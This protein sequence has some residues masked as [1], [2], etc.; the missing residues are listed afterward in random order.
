MPRLKLKIASRGLIGVV[1]SA[2]LLLPS[3]APANTEVSGTV[4]EKYRPALSLEG[5]FLAAYI[6]GIGRDT[7]AAA[8][9][10]RE[11][12]RDDPRNAELVE[13]AFV[14]FL[15]DNDMP[16]AFRLAERLIASDQN[17]SLAQLALGVR[18]FKAGEHASARK[19]FTKSAR[20]RTVDLTSIL[21]TAWSWAGS[22]N[23]KKA[24]EVAGQLKGNRAYTVFRDY[25]AGLIA[26][27]GGNTAE[28]ERRMKAAY[29]ADSNTLRIVEA[30]AELLSRHGNSQLA[31]SVYEAVEKV[32]P[33]QPLIR[34]S[35]QQL[36][37]GKVLP[38]LVRTAN[39]GAAEVLY[40][41]GAAGN[42][43]GEELP[44]VIYLRLALYL[45]PQHSMAM[46][47][48]AETFER[49][50]HIEQSVAV[51]K[52]VPEDSYLHAET[53]IQ[54]AYSLEQ[55]GRGD[56]AIKSLEALIGKNPK[57]SQALMA[58]GNIQRT[59]KM[60][61]EAA[62]TYTKALALLGDEGRVSWP[63]LF[64]RGTAY[65]R[66]KQWDKAEADLK[67]A[68]TMIP[69]NQPAG[70]AQVMNYL[71][72]SWVDNNTN[73]DEAF[74]LLQN[75]VELSPRDGMIIDSLGWAYYRLGRY[76]EAVKELE[77]A[78]EMKPGDPT[79]NEHLGDA[80]WKVGRKVEAG[81][82]WNHARDSSPE[83]EDLPKILNK[84]EHGMDETGT[85]A[86]S[87]N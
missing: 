35:L 28:A 76:D 87:A 19:H 46:V 42:S 37:S 44:A 36:R 23:T 67:K 64:Y 65:E 86:S 59:R 12:V 83:P 55:L 82:Q 13:R 3:P 52:T 27:L 39:E 62:A 15:A 72:Y 75:A 45:N 20:P 68:L 85:E 50:G 16:E 6:A 73:I 53:E 1:L 71:A 54:A 58:L 22:E 47:T 8:A 14:A 74:K 69:E 80:Y 81:F 11:A 41:L 4:A 18:D 10:Y 40:G 57:D 33:Q 84:I 34:W 2:L 26:E 79:I 61:P 5:N 48:L 78:V 17:H 51:L 49:M 63:I 25:H 24:L 32:A 7:A 77:K 30:Y 60:F 66:S 9:Y 29:E 31:Q 38:P 21:L 70:R 56:E 43:Q